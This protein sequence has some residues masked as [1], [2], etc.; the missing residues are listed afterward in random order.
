MS[1]ATAAENVS[2]QNLSEQSLMELHVYRILG[3]YPVF[4]VF[5]SLFASTA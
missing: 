5:T 3:N 2:E 1:I 4:I